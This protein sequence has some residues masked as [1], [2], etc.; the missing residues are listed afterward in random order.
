MTVFSDIQERRVPFLGI[1]GLRL[2]MKAFDR[3]M[4]EDPWPMA[5]KPARPLT[6]RPGLLPLL[7]VLVSIA[8]VSVLIAA[9][10]VTV[11]LSR[12]HSHA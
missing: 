10:P 9:V 12:S 8:Q 3:G 4:K 7:V 11:L 2:E 5:T 6:M 1:F